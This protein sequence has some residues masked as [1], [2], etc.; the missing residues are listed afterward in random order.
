[1]SFILKCFDDF[2]FYN[3]ALFDSFPNSSYQR[4]IFYRLKQ[5]EC[6]PRC[7]RL[8]THH[9][10]MVAVNCTL[11]GETLRIGRANKD[12]SCRFNRENC[13]SLNPAAVPLCLFNL[14]RRIRYHD[15]DRLW[16][17]GQQCG[18]EACYLKDR[19]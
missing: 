17:S 16:F 10:D 12:K 11:F 18:N 15:K 6:R 2:L 1:M 5:F 14:R 9:L 3:R 4:R 13:Y 8:F 7:K 19:G